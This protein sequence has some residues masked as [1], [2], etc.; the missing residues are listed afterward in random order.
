MTTQNYRNSLFVCLIIYLS[1]YMID[2]R[3]FTN[4][5]KTD[6]VGSGFPLSLSEWS[7]T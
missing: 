4:I 6:C 7:L 3:Y 2:I 1:I 5:H